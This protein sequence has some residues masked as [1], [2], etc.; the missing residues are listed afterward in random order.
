MRKFL[1]QFDSEKLSKF[2]QAG[3]YDISL[4]Q[5]RKLALKELEDLNDTAQK[6]DI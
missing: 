4:L 3:K 1:E 2:I 5:E 6:L